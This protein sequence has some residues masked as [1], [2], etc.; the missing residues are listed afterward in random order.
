MADAALTLV[1]LR[2]LAGRALGKVDAWGSRGATLVT[3]T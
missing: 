1:E 2:D 3:V